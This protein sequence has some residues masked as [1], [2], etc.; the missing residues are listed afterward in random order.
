MRLLVFLMMM[1][2]SAS[3]PIDRVGSALHASNATRHVTAKT[4]DTGKISGDLCERDCV[5][6]MYNDKCADCKC[7]GG[8]MFCNVKCDPDGSGSNC[9]VERYEINHDCN[10][11]WQCLEYEC[12]SGKCKQPSDEKKHPI[13]P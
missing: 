13:I 2:L 6:D 1:S 9:C 10:T 11:N 8:P 7:D 4:C 12:S 5:D 3:F